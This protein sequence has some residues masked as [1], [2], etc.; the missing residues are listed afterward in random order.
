MKI[1]ASA[2][3][4][5]MIKKNGLEP[6]FFF[7]GEGAAVVGAGFFGCGVDV[8]V[9]TARVGTSGTSTLSDTPARADFFAR[10]ALFFAT[11]PDDF[12]ARDALFFATRPDDFFARDALFFATRPDDF[13]ARD[14]LFLADFAE[15]DFFTARFATFFA[16]LL[17]DFFARFAA[18][19]LLL[20]RYRRSGK[21]DQE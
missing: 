19:E 12:F 2:T 20:A 6:F 17:A 14:A 3:T 5:M 1:K 11:R 9:A 13:F 4:P 8:G 16:G 18:T 21:V 7:S 10:D 15:D